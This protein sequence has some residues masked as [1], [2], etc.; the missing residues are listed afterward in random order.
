MAY[1]RFLEDSK[2]MDILYFVEELYIA[3]L[4]VLLLIHLLKQ[5]Q[6]NR[7]TRSIRPLK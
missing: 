5:Y 7:L 4:D 3:K 2:I 6:K 1:I